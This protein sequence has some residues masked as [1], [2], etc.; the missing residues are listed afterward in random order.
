MNA[1]MNAYMSYLMNIS[2]IFI[3]IQYDDVSSYIALKAFNCAVILLVGSVKNSLNIH[4]KNHILKSQNSTF[5]Q[6]QPN[7]STPH[8][9]LKYFI[10]YFFVYTKMQRSVCSLITTTVQFRSR[11][12]HFRN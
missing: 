4:T 10:V 1:F 2:F 7:S 12:L 9:L 8:E 5:S 3:E 6:R 11:A